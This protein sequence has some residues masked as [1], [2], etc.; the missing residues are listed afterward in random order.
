MFLSWIKKIKSVYALHVYNTISR[1]FVYLEK[2][3]FKTLILIN[4][5]KIGEN[6]C[7]KIGKPKQI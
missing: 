2:Q 3:T 5:M 1:Y 7:I 6:E 4:K